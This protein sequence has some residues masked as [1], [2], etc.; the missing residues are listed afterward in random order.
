MPKKKLATFSLQ[1]FHAFFYMFVHSVKS[2][3]EMLNSCRLALPT[4][5]WH[6]KASE[7]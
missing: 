6:C 4:A 1:Y 2:T 5:M 7:S 3:Q